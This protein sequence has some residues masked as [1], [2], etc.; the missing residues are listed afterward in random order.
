MKYWQ[1]SVKTPYTGEEIFDLRTRPQI[2]VGDS[3]SNNVCIDSTEIP[4]ALKMVDGSRS[5]LSGFKK[6]VRIRLTDEIIPSLQGNFLKKSDWKTRLY[7]GASFAATGAC[8]WKIGSTQFALSESESIPLAPIA[9][10]DRS[11]ENKHW[12]Q[13]YGSAAGLHAILFLLILSVSFFYKATHDSINPADIQKVSIQQV[14][15]VFDKTKAVAEL[16]PQK[17][18]EESTQV[19][20]LSKEIKEPTV[21]PIAKRAQAKKLL[22]KNVAAKVQVVASK[23]PSKRD[24]APRKNINSMGLL[25]I[26]STAKPTKTNLD[27]A[28]L[29]MGSAK[30]MASKK[31]GTG[32]GLTKGESNFGLLA[33]GG[34]VQVAQL[35]GKGVEAYQGGL[36]DK[37]RAGSMRGASIKLVRREI[38]IRGGL[39]PAVI[40]QIIEERLSEVRYCY[41]TALLKQTNLQGKISAT[42]TI[43]ADG[44]VAGLTSE[45]DEIKSTVL[46]PCIQEQIKNWKFPAPKGGGVVHV[47]YPFLFS[48]VGS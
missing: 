12:L 22:H 47:K 29:A 30:S 43:Q 39:D 38:E 14:H 20:E 16:S 40:R 32:L 1:L 10:E 37:V 11:V 7:S 27:V 17:A 25:A 8:D 9:A 41:E 21:S 26:Q 35:N 13:S 48:P 18:P 28:A 45:S 15:T 44:S 42:W 31:A 3:L 46:Q 6:E 24:P 4:A 2:L 33:N 5:I 23:V 34:G 36:G 19:A